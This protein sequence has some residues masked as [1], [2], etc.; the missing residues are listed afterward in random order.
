MR[1]DRQRYGHVHQFSFR[2]EELRA[3]HF[4]REPGPCRFVL[5]RHHVSHAVPPPPVVDPEPETNI[6]VRLA[7]IGRVT[8]VVGADI[9]LVDACLR[10]SEP[11]GEQLLQYVHPLGRRR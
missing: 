8:R 2:T 9:D 4:F 11:V 3:S 5:R 6:V 1:T 7:S 10:D